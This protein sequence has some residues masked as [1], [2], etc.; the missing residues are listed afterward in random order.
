M[1]PPLPPVFSFLT[2]KLPMVPLFV[3]I[4]LTPSF[5]LE[6]IVPMLPPELFVIPV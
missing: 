6:T 1:V 5:V 4:L 2:S 3:I